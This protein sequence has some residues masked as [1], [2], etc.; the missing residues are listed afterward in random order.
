MEKTNELVVEVL[1][2]WTEDAVVRVQVT[3]EVTARGIAREAEARAAWLRSRPVARGFEKRESGLLAELDTL[4]ARARVAALME[5]REGGSAAEREKEMGELDR[6]SFCCFSRFR[7]LVA[8][9][10][11][12]FPSRVKPESPEDRARELAAIEAFLKAR[13]EVSSDEG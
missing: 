3:R 2:G 11:E 4:A 1:V 12:P 13:K 5:E 8:A 7:D 10:D 6:L 9:I